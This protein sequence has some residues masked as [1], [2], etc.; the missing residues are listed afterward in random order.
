MKYFLQKKVSS[1]A[2][3]SAIVKKIHI[4]H[5]NFGFYFDNINTVRVFSDSKEVL[6]RLEI[7]DDIQRVPEHTQ[8]MQCIRVRALE[9]QTPRQKTKR[10]ARL[11]EH[12]AK[13]G[14]QYKEDYTKPQ[15][16]H[17]YFINMHSISNGSSFRLY[18]HNKIVNNRNNELFSS[19]GLSLN[20][21]TIPYF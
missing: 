11:K 4:S 15:A 16:R 18:V 14:I 17:D 9:R 3:I 19:Y 2:E 5:Y 20:G 10:I 12:L 21:A 8:Y 13:K 1:H 7:N 6:Q